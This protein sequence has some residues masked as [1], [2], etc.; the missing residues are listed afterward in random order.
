MEPAT[1][2]ARR[3][4]SNHRNF[5]LKVLNPKLVSFFFAFSFLTACRLDSGGKIISRRR[6]KMIKEE[7]QKPPEICDYL[8]VFQRM[9]MILAKVPILFSCPHI[10]QVFVDIT[11]DYQLKDTIKKLWFGYLELW[12]AS[13]QHML[14]SLLSETRKDIVETDEKKIEEGEIREIPVP[15]KQILL[16]LIYLALRLRKSWILPNDIVRWVCDGKIPYLNLYAL[17]PEDTQFR[18]RLFTH[19]HRIFNRDNLLTPSP[20]SS[21]NVLFHSILLSQLMKIPYPAL[22]GPLQCYVLTLSLGLPYQIIWPIVVRLSQMYSQF[23]PIE[24]CQLFR[25]Y[26]YES[27]ALTVFTSC[28]LSP[29]WLTTWSYEP[30]E[31]SKSEKPQ[32]SSEL[33]TDS[34]RYFQIIE[35]P[36]LL[37]KYQ[38]NYPEISREVDR[39]HRK[40]FQSRPNFKKNIFPYQDRIFLPKSVEECD[41]V[42]NRANL[43]D[44]LV[45]IQNAMR[46]IDRSTRLG[47]MYDSSGFLSFNATLMRILNQITPSG[48]SF[49][50]TLL[51]NPSS[52]I[53]QSHFSQSLSQS[54]PSSQ[55]RT[56]SQSQ[57]AYP[58]TSH[59]KYDTS[60]YSY[61]ATI[62]PG[63]PISYSWVSID[64]SLALKRAYAH[65]SLF[66]Q[67]QKKKHKEY[68]TYI[69]YQGCNSEESIGSF[70]PPYQMLLERISKHMTLSSGYLY[71][72]QVDIDDKLLLIA[73]NIHQN[74]QR[75]AQAK[76]RL[77]RYEL[78][79]LASTFSSTSTSLSSIG[80]SRKFTEESI[81]EFANYYKYVFPMLQKFA[82]FIDSIG[83]DD[84]NGNSD[85]QHVDEV[86][87]ELNRDEEMEDEAISEEE[88]FM[89]YR[90][91][92]QGSD[93]S[94]GSLMA[95]FPKE[96]SYQ[97]LWDSQSMYDTLNRMVSHESDEKLI[98]GEKEQ[99]SPEPEKS[100]ELGGV[101][102]LLNFSSIESIRDDSCI[103]SKTDPKS[104]GKGARKSRRLKNGGLPLRP[105]PLDPRVILDDGDDH[106]ISQQNYEQRTT[107]LGLHGGEANNLRYP[108]RS[109]RSESRLRKPLGGVRYI[110]EISDDEEADEDYVPESSGE[111]EEIDRNEV[112]GQESR[113]KRKRELSRFI[114]E[115]VDE[116]PP[117]NRRRTEKQRPLAIQ[118]SAPREEEVIEEEEVFEE[119]EILFE[120]ETEPEVAV[121][122]EREGIPQEILGQLKDYAEL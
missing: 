21:M 66:N 56:S 13:D 23:S 37:E 34:L 7:A 8:E 31:L 10:C 103:E 68:Y 14:P 88:E 54:T 25:Q 118:Q 26:F 4:A 58:V 15:S 72:L 98:S 11:K 48:S 61:G 84:I 32:S 2:S 78:H 35:E 85:S 77:R 94:R 40:Y 52:L 22:N 116:K 51:H 100:A 63:N 3:V 109:T 108:R 47:S 16:G 1:I 60:M 41:H 86:Q 20:L 55:V 53:S 18:F 71:S 62:L 65:T 119:E 81:G 111:E 114:I 12:S 70:H 106:G 67:N 115:R 46:T 49:F 19:C 27:I 9:L 79:Q 105:Q 107:P 101:Q 64:D 44:V 59:S 74:L 30:F 102:I 89:L 80:K 87:F 120:A 29:C 42:I 33:T 92:T 69:T 90:R 93:S 112:A 122:D 104:R 97:S 75:R 17:V 113:P 83:Q 96:S 110:Q 24:E 6:I 82:G 99:T 36:P 95:S 121:E 76:Q 5:S 50:Q 28:Q 117:R 39:T 38:I 43:I 57:H 73:Q 45:H 91:R